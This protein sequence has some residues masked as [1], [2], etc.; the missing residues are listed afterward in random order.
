[1]STRP[2]RPDLQPPDLSPPSRPTSPAPQRIA[3]D[4]PR[5]AAAAQLETHDAVVR[6]VQEGRVRVVNLSTKVLEYVMQQLR[7]RYADSGITI[8]NQVLIALRKEGLEID[9]DDIQ[10]ERKRPRR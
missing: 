2:G 5:F 1:M 3:A 8:R 4:D 7:R 9:E 10:D 6:G